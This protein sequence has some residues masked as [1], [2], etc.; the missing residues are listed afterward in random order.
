MGGS[1]ELKLIPLIVQDAATKQVLSLVYANSESIEL[2]KKTGFVHRYSR[3]AR[4]QMRKGETSGN[5]QKI[6]SLDE[7]CDGD[8]LLAVVNQ[9]GSGAC[10]AGGWSCFSTDRQVSY[11]VLDELIRTINERKTKPSENSFVSSIISDKEKI[12]GKLREE[13]NELSEA[14]SKKNDSEVV[15]EVAD[16]L[17]FTLVALENRGIS[18]ERV[19]DEL[20]RRRK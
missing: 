19:L 7:D 14:L 20:N 2:M 1:D 12:G 16:L 17:F 13:A 11:G 8:A 4:A 6:I 18:F 15:W 3:Q 9:E 10:H 5:F